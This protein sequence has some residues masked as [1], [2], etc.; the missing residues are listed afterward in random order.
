MGPPPE[1]KSPQLRQTRDRWLLRFWI[2]E[3]ILGLGGRAARLLALMA[4][5]LALGYYAIHETIIKKSH[6]P[7]PVTTLIR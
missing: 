7:P 5:M 6:A 2:W 1:F 4:V 3:H